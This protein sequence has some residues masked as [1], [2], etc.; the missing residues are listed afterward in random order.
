MFFFQ[1]PWL[2]AA[3]HANANV[4]SAYLRVAVNGDGDGDGDGDEGPGSCFALEC[5]SARGSL[6]AGA[7]E[8]EGTKVAALLSRSPSGSEK[9]SYQPATVFLCRLLGV[10]F[11]K[12]SWSLP[13]CAGP[14][15]RGDHARP[16]ASTRHRLPWVFH[17]PAGS[18]IPEFLD[19][20]WQS[21]MLEIVALGRHDP[22]RYLPRLAGFFISPW[23]KRMRVRC[24]V[25]QITGGLWLSGIAKRHDVESL[26]DFFRGKGLSATIDADGN[27]L[28][29]GLAME[30]FFKLVDD[31]NIALV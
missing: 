27:V 1:I 21:A 28:L 26:C 20:L 25:V 12:C 14:A 13:P 6:V 7:L 19:G 10:K 23:I 5:W 22:A 8:V 4:T 18:G 9:N 17:A 29:L 16:T 31:A 15:D 30:R 11:S 3:G 24:H 2:P